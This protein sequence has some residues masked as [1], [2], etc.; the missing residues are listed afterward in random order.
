MAVI[1]QLFVHARDQRDHDRLEEAVSAR[2]EAQGGPP[3]G[4]MAHLGYP[5][6]GGFVIVD[7]WRDE[8]AF[9]GF[10]DAVLVDAL[11]ESGLVA[12]E[13]E[14]AQAWSIARP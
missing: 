5:R 6:D 11:A 9:R 3:D 7:A 13:P 1:A 2:L 8:A 4:L 14:L 12:D 10:F